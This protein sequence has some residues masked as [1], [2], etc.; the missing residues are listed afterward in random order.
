MERSGPAAW[1]FLLCGVLTAAGLGGCLG[2]G[3]GGVPSG[4]VVAFS[5]TDIPSG[6]TLCDGRDTPGGA[7]TPDL[8]ERFVL[9]TVP[10][11]GELGESGGDASH[12]HG[13]E[14]GP[15]TGK[16][17]GV[18]PDRDASLPNREHG[19]ELSPA[20]HMPPYVKLVYI[21]KN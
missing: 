8:R 19:H 2:G 6:W 17:M 1:L 9:G 20:A 3:G 11:S 16:R 21:M 18:D 13:G 15:P 4:T 12:D 5:G 14:T 7:P 10:E